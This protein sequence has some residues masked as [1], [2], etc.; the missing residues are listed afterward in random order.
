MRISAIRRLAASAALVLMFLP[1]P[2]GATATRGGASCE[3]WLQ[4]KKADGWE[5]TA[6][7]FWL[8]GYLSGLA[9]ALNEDLLTRRSNDAIFEWMDSYCV[10]APSKGIGEAANALARQLIDE[11]AAKLR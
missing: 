7:H 11:S 8:L 5:I 6:D 10:T 3:Q 4:D 1:C 9:V 2:V